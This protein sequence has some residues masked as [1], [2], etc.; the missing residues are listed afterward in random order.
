MNPWMGDRAHRKTSTYTGQ[1]I[2]EKRRHIHA[3]CEFRT[4]D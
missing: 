2:T 4:R 1:H 3:T